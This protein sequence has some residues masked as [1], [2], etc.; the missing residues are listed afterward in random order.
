MVR[1]VSKSS[2]FNWKAEFKPPSSTS[3]DTLEIRSLYQKPFHVSEDGPGAKA[4]WD[5]VVWLP[6]Q[7]DFVNRFYGGRSFFKCRSMCARNR[8]CASLQKG[9]TSDIA[10]LGCVNPIDTI[11]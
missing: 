8:S 10:G 5:M 4:R 7:V 3:S 1:T 11:D 9:A 2:K 6:C